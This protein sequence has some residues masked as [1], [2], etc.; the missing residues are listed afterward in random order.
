[1]GDPDNYRDPQRRRRLFLPGM[2]TTEVLR[3]VL[4]IDD[5]EKLRSLLAR[6][7]SLEGYEVVQAGDAKQAF[8]KL[9]AMEV[10]VV[11]CDVK[12]PDANGVELSKAIKEKYPAIEIILLTAYGNIPDG[13]KAIKYGAF[14]Y[15][16]KGDDNDRI[17]PL[18]A[19]AFAKANLR[20]ANQPVVGEGE[21][22]FDQIIGKAPAIWQAVAIAKKVAA[23]DA[24]V[25]LTGETGVGK[26]VFASAM[27][28]ASHRAGHPF[29][30]VN[31][32]AI[33]KDLIESELFGHAAGA[34][35]G[36]AKARTGW[37]EAANHGTIFLDEIGEMPADMQA[38]LLRVLE[39]GEFMKVGE[40]K[41]TRVDVRI[42]AA[43]NRDLLKEIQQGHFRQDLYY[44]L[45]TFQIAIP[46]LRH[47][48]SD[49]PLLAQYFMKQLAAKM[50]T[51][52]A[53][54]PDSYVLALQ[55]YDWPGNIRE[56]KNAIERSLILADNQPLSVSDL[57]PEV[58][59]LPQGFDESGKRISSLDLASV[60]KEHIKKVLQH[61]A[62]NK[63]EAARLLHIG[64]TTLYRKLEEY[65][66]R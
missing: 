66:I 46:A 20:K 25:L 4:I 60:E 51:A 62:G 36:A 19:E 39:A 30:A 43:T 55:A 63:T 52:P 26:E 13:V 35:T 17:L 49:I 44:R 56:L 64:L 33:S 6:I 65:Q 1:M 29:V 14:D 9:A 61:T 50:N 22:G 11:L 37:F 3:R 27:H 12:L 31:C 42:I 16:T 18:L 47:R 28:K 10:A 54:M 7:I 34:F 58:Q 5:E 53:D 23:T 15:I 57:P 38:K 32:A 21:K 40:S 48:K 59:A 24:A 2:N 41:S 8:K 45:S